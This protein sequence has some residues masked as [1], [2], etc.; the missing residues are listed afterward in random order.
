MHAWQYNIILGC[1]CMS[2]LYKCLSYIPKAALHGDAY[3][4]DFDC[5]LSKLLDNNDINVYSMSSPAMTI[6]WVQDKC[7]TW[8]KIAN[9]QTCSQQSSLT[10]TVSG[11]KDGG[12]VADHLNVS[13]S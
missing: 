9:G 12:M 11:C 6:A 5:L 1:V 3:E 4:N 7:Y 10:I 2:G 13:Q 8:P